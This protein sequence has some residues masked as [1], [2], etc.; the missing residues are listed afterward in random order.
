MLRLGVGRGDTVASLAWNTRG[1]FELWYAA[2]GI[3]AVCHTLNPRLT[4]EQLAAMTA[5]SRPRLLFH[6][7]G[8]EALAGD[9]AIATEARPA[10][11]AL[12]RDGPGSSSALIDAEHLSADWAGGREED[13]A[14]LCF[15]SGTTGAPKGVL[16]SHRSN[17]LHT[18]RLLQ[19][20]ALALSA[21]DRVLAAVPMFH[22]NGWG[23]PFAAPAVGATLVLPGRRL[24][25]AS[26]AGLMQRER[27]TVAAGVPTVWLDLVDHLEKTGETLPALQRI[28][29][30]GA[31]LPVEVQ[32]RLE[33]RLRA[34]VNTSWGMT[35]LSPLGTVSPGGVSATL[36]GSSGRPPIGADLRL[37]DEHGGE[38]V[39]QRGP[40]G[41]LQVRGHSVV[42]RYYGVEASATDEE[43]WFDTGD[44]ARIGEGGDLT[45]TGRAK[46]LIKSGGEWINPAEI[47]R[48][49]GGLAGVAQAAVI[50]RIDARWGERPVLVV[51]LA[52]GARLA[53]AAFALAFE[54][55][56]ARWWMPDAVHR[57]E[58]MPLASTGKIDKTALRKSFGG[59]ASEGTTV[60]SEERRRA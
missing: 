14:G 27:V 17:Y 60:A 51:E 8:L 28:Y 36:P 49:A 1:H 31:A 23:L 29:L 58:R 15:T 10:L 34:S 21:E 37:V 52:P 38:L 26:L 39:E 56:I 22:A 4:A 24:D 44:L 19:A 16:Y 9:V 43:G 50:G 11:L 2:A 42:A 5:M 25:G 35:E 18:L 7:E 55:R 40:E 3:G 48:L 53:D 59:D 54:G 47:E 45:I 12:D 57:V 41:R 20:D 32:R 33:K 30:G 46:D 13:A 6:G